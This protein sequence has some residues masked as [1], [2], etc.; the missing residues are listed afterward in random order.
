MP[1]KRKVVVYLFLA[2]VI[3][4]VSAFVHKFR[5]DIVQV[6]IPFF[7]ALIIAYLINPLI[8]KLESKGIP[9]VAGILA[10]YIA[11]A[12][13]VVTVIIF[14]I[15]EF[16]NN[17]RELMNT[18]PDIISRYQDIFND[19]MSF[20]KTS[21]WP[22]DIKNAIYDEIQNG[23]EAV[24]NFTTDAL[25]R[26]L[27]IMLKTATMLLDLILA[28]TI[29]YY[30]MKDGEFFKTAALSLTPRRWRNGIIG[31]GREINLI[32]SSFIQGQIMVA[33]IIGIMEIIGLYIIDIKYPLVLGMIGGVANI[34]PYF[35]PFIGAVPAIAV[36]LID[37]PLKA[38]WAVVV[39]TL[40]QQID[41]SF[42]SPKI[43]EGKLGLHPVTT[44]LAVLAGGELFGII[45][46]LVSV[47][48]AAVIK[49]I[50]KRAV[51]AIV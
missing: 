46:M 24:Q 45:G 18:L 23:A 39:F 19:F 43:I 42:I 51:E 32:L 44:I 30:F 14:I 7:L 6:G 48:I 9:R 5:S 21:N 2:F 13:I 31:T 28:M 25:R 22:P 35:G 38:L 16:V 1:S 49:I 37:S 41:N 12:A 20:I 47:P 29:A 50:I 4:A 40:V 33:F 8:K 34:I 36:A 17:T 3:L 26:S 15:P 27:M 10:V 11:F